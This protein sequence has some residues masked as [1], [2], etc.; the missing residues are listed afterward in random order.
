MPHDYM[1]GGYSGARKSF[2]GWGAKKRKMDSS[3]PRIVVGETYP[4]LCG[5]LMGDVFSSL[6]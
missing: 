1:Y 6:S 5:R 3:D 2:V 4:T